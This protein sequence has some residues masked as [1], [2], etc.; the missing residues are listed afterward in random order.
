MNDWFEA[1]E[2]VER[3]RQHFEANRWTEAEAELRDAISIDPYRSEWHFNL[4]LTLEATGRDAEAQRSFRA[5]YDLDSTNDSTL[6]ALGLNALRL[7]D[8]ASAIRWFEEAERVR[9]ECPDSY[10]HRIEAYARLNDHEQAEVMF[11]MAIQMSDVDE[12]CAYLNM[13]ESLLDR[14]ECDRAIWCL[15]TAAKADPTLQR[16]HARLAEAH[17]TLGRLDRARQLYLRELRNNPGDIETLLDLGC[18]LVEMNRLGEA[19]E[20]FRR[21]LELETDNADAHFY[22]GDLAERQGQRDS[23]IASHRLVLRLDPQHSAARRRLAGLLAR[24][25]D[26]LDAQRLLQRELR[27]LDHD[28]VA[29]TDA[30]LEEFGSLL[31]DAQLPDDA[32]RALTILIDRRPD[33]ARALHTLAV[34]CLCAG[35]LKQGRKWCHAALRIDP[36]CVP[37]M[38]NLAL[39]LMREGKW[40][41]ARRWVRRARRIDADDPSLRRL[42]AKIWL[43]GAGQTL[44]AIRGWFGLLWRRALVVTRR[45]G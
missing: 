24:R 29:F 42:R 18:L 15:R 20:K 25:G 7:D 44:R 43:H 5:A 2:H 14:N 19:G 3:A 32:I 28:A 27:L 10:V 35:D 6:L 26:L 45:A 40:V 33:S 13:A 39:A 11:Y 23:A 36:E 8:P 17:A 16:V 37:A 31:L 34:A 30:D 12:A 38:H 41:K 9:P 4:G 21:V 22:L 1:E